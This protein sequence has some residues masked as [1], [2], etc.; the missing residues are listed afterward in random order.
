MCYLK[1]L[2]NLIVINVKLKRLLYAFGL[3]F[4]NHR[5][6]YSSTLTLTVAAFLLLFL[7]EEWFKVNFN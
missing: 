1:N 5:R 4:T 6:L 3:F 7:G 2:N